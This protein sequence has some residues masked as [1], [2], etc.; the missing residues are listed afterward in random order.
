M[1]KDGDGAGAAG[2]GGRVSGNKGLNMGIGTVGVRF[3]GSG[4]RIWGIWGGKMGGIGG[5]K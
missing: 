4:G 1:L 3:W 2:G 5:E